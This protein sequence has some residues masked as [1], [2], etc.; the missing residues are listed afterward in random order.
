M[1]EQKNGKDCLQTVLSEGL[2]IDYDTIPKFYENNDTW[3]KDYNN[4]LK[5]HGLFRVIFDM[6]FSDNLVFPYCS[7]L[8]VLLIGILHKPPRKHEHAVILEFEETNVIMND[9]KPNSDYDL[10]DL[11]QVE[12]IFEGE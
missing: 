5:S 4:W 9:P 7:R 3:N 10:T 11:C 1:K 8:P 2:Q 12:M 6:K